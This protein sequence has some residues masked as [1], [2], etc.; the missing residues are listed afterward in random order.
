MKR[1]RDT[2][3]RIALRVFL[4][5]TLLAMLAGSQTRASE[6]RFFGSI[7]SESHITSA[8]PESP[9]NPE[10]FLRI[11]SVSN[12]SD[13]VLF[14]EAIPEDK[15]WKFHFKLR[16]EAEWRRGFTS[17][18]EVSELYGSI[19][20]TPWLDLQA[21]RKIEKW[22]T[23][24][25]WNPTGV[26]NP[27]K[28]PSD[29]NDRRSAFRGAD[30]FGA[31]LFVKGWNVSLLAVPQLDFQKQ[32]SRLLAGTGW[33]ARAYKLVRG[34]DLSFTFS[35][36]NS[37]PNHQGI[38]FARVFGNALE[39]HGELARFQD[40]LQPTAGGGAWRLR[41]RS[42]TEVLLG[43]QY[44]FPRNVNL[45][46][47]YF[48]S[49][50]GLSSQDWKRFRDDA[51]DGLRALESGNPFPLLQQNRQFAPLRMGQDYS[52]VRASWPIRLNTL[53]AELLVITS[54]RDGSSMIR[55]GI[56]WKVRPNWSLYWLQSQFIG[57]AATEF[58][59][60]Q[61]RRSSDFGLRFSF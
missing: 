13:L 47:E 35:G 11:P 20:V 17:R 58:G 14:G 29:P 40:S 46:A 43:A 51:R 33:A 53:E 36:G 19:S 28:N 26:V 15:S 18:A 45:I 32:S 21:G 8:N 25:A 37:L 57:G 34:V 5:S 30:M 7:G 10:N 4:M 61:V 49:G 59:H 48:H 42:S 52:F 54:L 3:E 6:F 22:G 44:T 38:S 12:S 16:G 2:F 23:G 60:L 55:P 27:A 9:L 56:T 1:C 41:R 50:T 31:E 39:L 24:Y